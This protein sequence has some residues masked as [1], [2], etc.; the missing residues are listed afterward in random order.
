LRF[1]PMLALYRS[2]RQ[3]EA[4]AVYQ[5]ARGALV[6][7]LGIEPTQ[8]LRELEN[9]ILRQDPALDIAVKA[10]LGVEKSLGVVESPLAEPPPSSHERKRATVLLADLVGSTEFG[11][12]DPERTRALLERFYDAMA[13]EI[14]R[15]GGTVE[16]FMVRLEPPPAA[17]LLAPTS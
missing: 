13:E 15:A 3:A 14:E 9:A 17:I 1:L 16:K 12:Q 10:E 11:E 6:D 8:A 2:G 7:E 4:L 5:D